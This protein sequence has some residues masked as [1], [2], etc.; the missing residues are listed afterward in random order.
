MILVAGHFRIP[1]ANLEQAR[2]A[3]CRVVEETRREQGC[4]SYSYAEDMCEP[5][6]IRVSESWVSGAALDAHLASPHMQ[7]WRDERTAL[8]LS[9]RDITRYE[10]ASAEPF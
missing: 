2:P 3:M 8:G 9:D 4:I 5:G 6:L 10:V 1:P 7:R